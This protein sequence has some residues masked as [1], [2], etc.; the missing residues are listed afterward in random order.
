MASGCDEARTGWVA[1]PV[2]WLR[3]GAAGGSSYVDQAMAFWRLA[4]IASRN[5][6][7]VR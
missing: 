2:A 7:V 4:S 1:G 3:A 5:C 6:S